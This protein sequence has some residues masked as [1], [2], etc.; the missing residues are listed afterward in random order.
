MS[1]I[2]EMTEKRIIRKKVLYSI[3]DMQGFV[4]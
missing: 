2:D 1:Q 4:I 3:V